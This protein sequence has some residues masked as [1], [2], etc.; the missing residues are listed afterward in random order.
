MFTVSLMLPIP[1]AVLPEAPAVAVE[2]Y[3]TLVN[4]DEK[5]SVIH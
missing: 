3:D 5:L 2:V 1:D 4:C